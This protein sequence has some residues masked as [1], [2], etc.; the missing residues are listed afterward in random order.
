MLYYFKSEITVVSGQCPVV[1]GQQLSN[2]LRVPDYKAMQKI[3]LFFYK[4]AELIQIKPVGLPTL[5][6]FNY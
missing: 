3:C 6:I 2:A 4:S 5:L 1:S